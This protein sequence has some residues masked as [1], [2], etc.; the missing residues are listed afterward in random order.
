MYEVLTGRPPFKGKDVVDTMAQ[1]RKKE[2]VRPRTVCP[3]V[4]R[5]LETICLTC[6]AKDPARRYGSAEALADDLDRWVRREPIAAR[7]VGRAE[8]ATKWVSRNPLVTALAGTSIL[9]L[10]AAFGG[11]VVLGYSRT[12][13]EKNHELEIANA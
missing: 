13:A 9:L 10:L 1:V 6:L 7:P 5:D 2:P 12:L 8:R 4:D 3:A 11:L